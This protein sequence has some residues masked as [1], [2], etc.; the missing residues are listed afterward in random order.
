MSL[1]LGTFE[2]THV[3]FFPSYISLSLNFHD[4][5]KQSTSN[6]ADGNLDYCGGQWTYPR[7]C[8]RGDDCEYFAKWNYDENTDMVNFIVE[9]KNLNKWTGIGFS[10]TPQMV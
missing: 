3:I 6:N 4:E 9:S 8:T 2:C 10:E 5:V 1:L 7:T